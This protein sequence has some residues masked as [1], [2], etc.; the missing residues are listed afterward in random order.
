MSKNNEQLQEA[1]SALMDNEASELELRRILRDSKEDPGPMAVWHRYQLAASAMRRELPA[2]IVDLSSRISQAL[3]HEAP[4]AMG[5]SKWLQPAG[6]VA[7]AASVAVVA[8]FGVQQLQLR[9]GVSEP[10]A[11]AL[12]AANPP[13]VAEQSGPLFQLPA[14]YELPAVSA[15][16]V[17]VSANPQRSVDYRP[18]LVV[19]RLVQDPATQ[20]EIQSYLNQAMSQ[21]TENAARSTVHGVLPYARLPA[22]ETDGR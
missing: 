1:L 13:A 9:P 3:E 19:K 22:S 6:R 17:S 5:W 12:S 2:G 7:I 15:R 4:P 18:M 8:L 10:A 20:E 16:T 21:H 14:G 11:V